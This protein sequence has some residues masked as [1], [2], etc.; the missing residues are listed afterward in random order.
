M[1]VGDSFKLDKWATDKARS[2]FRDI[3]IVLRL[4]VE[5]DRYEPFVL[6]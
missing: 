3:V 5:D 4:T 1:V 2:L 6:L